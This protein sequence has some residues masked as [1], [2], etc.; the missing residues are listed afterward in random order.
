MHT[1][2]VKIKIINNN[3]FYSRVQQVACGRQHIRQVVDRFVSANDFRV[4][5][6]V[7]DLLSSL[8]LFLLLKTYIYIYNIYFAG[9]LRF[10][11]QSKTGGLVKVYD[12]ELMPGVSVKCYNKLFVCLCVCAQI[13]EP[14][15][16]GGRGNS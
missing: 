11:L 5:V 10:C 14:H 8:L 7:C 16:A 2:A 6:C 3:N 15:W 1:Q 12:G 9:F 13:K 4:L